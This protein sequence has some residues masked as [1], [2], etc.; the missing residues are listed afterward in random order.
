[1]SSVI[2]HA[3]ARRDD[4]P[5]TSV[6]DF[7]AIAWACDRNGRCV[8]VD[9]VWLKFSG[10][11]IDEAAD[12]GWMRCMHP[13]DAPQMLTEFRAAQVR[14]APFRLEFRVRRFDGVWR[15]VTV[16][17]SPRRDPANAFDG[18]LGTMLDIDDR[19][20]AENAVRESE[21]RLRFALETSGMF[22]WEIDLAT[23]IV[24][25]SPGHDA[26]FGYQSPVADWTPGTFLG[27]VVPQDRAAV[28]A[29]LQ[30]L[31]ADGANLS[32]EARI[33]RVD[34]DI[35]WIHAAARSHVRDGRRCV[36][37]VIQDITE[38]KLAEA[39]LLE[40][41]TRF[42]KLFENAATGIALVEADGRLSRVNDSFVDFIGYARDDLLRM[43]WRD[44]AFADD[45][46]RVEA[47]LRLLTQGDAES[48]EIESRCV[49][50]DG[51][52][53]W[54]HKCISALRETPGVGGQC[55]VFVT[56]ID[57]RRRMEQALREATR[58]K[59]AFLA[60]LAHELRN[61]LAS[62]HNGLHVSRRMEGAPPREL[63]G[64]MMRQADHLVRMVD[65]L[66]DVSRID[67][68]KIELRR[69]AVELSD[70]LRSALECCAR[71]I[72]LKRHRVVF[73]FASGPLKVDADSM[74]LT[75]VFANL[76]DNAAKFAPPE[77]TIGIRSRCDGAEAVI[78]VCDDG[79]GID[80]DVLP[81]VFDL[82]AQGDGARQGLGVGLALARQLVELH[83]GRIAA[84]S[85][86]AGRGSVFTVWLPLATPANLAPG[87]EISSAS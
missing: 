44:L 6:A 64:M 16:I 36:S 42:R 4:E 41:D 85:A 10:Q 39:A 47:G 40:S 53:V 55:V 68:G 22:A 28:E 61:P 81:G 62:I 76:L 82:F 21:A 50:K 7:R 11:S 63:L 30:A 46:A 38:R 20:R 17:A 43:R 79:P 29:S 8:H 58:R 80:G 37:G 65:D 57:D 34:G 78:E 15:Y 75:Q 25:R 69:R 12:G 13:D 70:I 73:E 77:G 48:F 60:T 3:A 71:Q 72:E 2:D 74:R 23:F 59:D 66:V 24:L 54:A 5:A 86:G 35:R 84:T 67:H 27:H 51:T 49:R 52:T 19:R 14:G 32:I 87:A 83:G 1:M 26:L 33:R 56:D 45:H 31:M 18:Y 9:P